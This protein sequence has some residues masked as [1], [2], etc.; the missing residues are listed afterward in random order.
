MESK[1]ANSPASYTQYFLGK[2]FVQLV[3]TDCLSGA[4]VE[5]VPLI[6]LFAKW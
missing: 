3:I 1:S 5:F 6:G 2:H 4:I